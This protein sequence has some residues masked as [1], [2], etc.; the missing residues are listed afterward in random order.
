MQDARSFAF[1][2]QGFVGFGWLV[3]RP[4]LNQDEHLME[5]FRSQELGLLDRGLLGCRYRPDRLLGCRSRM[6]P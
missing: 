3:S 5:C 6:V 4:P 2:N 1:R